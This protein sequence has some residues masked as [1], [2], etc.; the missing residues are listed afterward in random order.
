MWQSTTPRI[1]ELIYYSDNLEKGTTDGGHVKIKSEMHDTT[2]EN[3]YVNQ[4]IFALTLFIDDHCEFR[5]VGRLKTTN[6]QVNPPSAS[7]KTRRATVVMK[8]A[9]PT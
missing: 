4:G 3:Q 2:A 9:E 5:P 7:G 6:G 8:L 1:T